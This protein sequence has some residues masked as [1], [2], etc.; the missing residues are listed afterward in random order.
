L[1]EFYLLQIVVDVAPGVAD[2]VGEDLPA[3][4]QPRRLAQQGA[5]AVAV[6]DAVAQDQADRLAVDEALAQDERL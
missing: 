6:V 1:R 3:P 2:G 4:L 5:E